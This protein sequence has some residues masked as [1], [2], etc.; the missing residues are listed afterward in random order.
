MEELGRGHLTQRL[1]MSQDD[2]LGETARAMDLLAESLQ[3]EVVVLTVTSL[4]WSDP[5]MTATWSGAP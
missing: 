1:A 3:Q 4:S 2:E 5:R